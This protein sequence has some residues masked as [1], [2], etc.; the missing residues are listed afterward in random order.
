MRK[1]Y[2]ICDFLSEANKRHMRSVA[3][4]CGFEMGF[5]ESSEEAAGKIGDAEVVYCDDGILNSIFTT[6][7]NY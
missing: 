2:A 7:K 4:E 6:S 5:F 3:E 1:C